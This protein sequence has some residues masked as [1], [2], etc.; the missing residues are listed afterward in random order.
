MRIPALFLAALAVDAAAQPAPSA[1][2]WAKARRVLTTTPLVD[3]HNDL[4]WKIREAGKPPMDVEQYDLRKA[5]I[6]RTAFAR[7]KAGMIGAQFWSV[8]V[9]GEY[10][11]SG[12]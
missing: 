6:G 7:L 11:D 9:P 8:Y 10:K 12:F 3:S 4:P 5:T 2:D 1:A